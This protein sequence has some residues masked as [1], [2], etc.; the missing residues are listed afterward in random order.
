MTNEREIDAREAAIRSGAAL[1]EAM[2]GFHPTGWDASKKELT[3]AFTVK[4]EFCHTNASIAQGGFVTA[5]L[6]A[7]MAHA[8]MADSDHALTVASLD[9]KVSFLARVGPG[10]GRV[11]GR[12]VRRGNRIAFLEGDLYNADG[13][14]AAAATSTGLVIPYSKPGAG[15]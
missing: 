4:R 2:G 7:A 5:W 15:A 3:A 9:I 1:F 14:H 10:P 12:I 8:V 6:D 11:V 13:V